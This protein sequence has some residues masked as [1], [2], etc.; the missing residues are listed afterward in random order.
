MKRTKAI[1][2]PL[3]LLALLTACG[4]KNDPSASNPM[5]S[6]INSTPDVTAPVVTVPDKPSTIQVSPSPSQLPSTD[7]AIEHA[8]SRGLLWAEEI[9]LVD[10]ADM[11]L[12]TLFLYGG[13]P[14]YDGTGMWGDGEEWMMLVEVDGRQF[15]L[16]KN[17]IAPYRF[18]NCE[19]IIDGNNATHIILKVVVHF[20]GVDIIDW[21]WDSES[22]TFHRE[23]ILNMMHSM[24]PFSDEPYDAYGTAYSSEIIIPDPNKRTGLT[25]IWTQEANKQNNELPITLYEDGE[26]RLLAFEDGVNFCPLLFGGDVAKIDWNCF[27]IGSADAQD[28]ID[29]L[30]VTQ[31]PTQDIY[32]ITIFTWDWQMKRSEKTTIYR[33]EGIQ[34]VTRSPYDMN[35]ERFRDCL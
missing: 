4:G 2:I 5:P 33:A 28:Y 15:T 22:Q 18:I 10:G 30:L 31:Q 8:S 27:S 26:D 14:K 12:G 23:E 17:F 24:E 29:H 1:C 7:S 32:E 25:P 19:T 11:S 21:V 20:A 9:P 3:L 35:G 16:Q 6:I 34:Y 13:L